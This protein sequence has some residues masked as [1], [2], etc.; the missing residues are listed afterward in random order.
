M[1][2]TERNMNQDDEHLKLL[3][4]FHYVVGGITALFA[5]FPALH[6]IVGLIM[7]F[8][9]F[10][11]EAEGEPPPELFGWFFVVAGAVMVVIGWTIALVI[12]TAGRFLARRKHHLFCLVVAGVE[13]LFFPFGTV[14]GVFTIIVLMRPSVQQAFEANGPWQQ[15]PPGFP[16]A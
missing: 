12:L 16:P 15:P 8:A 13:C 14:L 11:A 6:V 7:V 10:P 1:D 5:S 2:R 4:V 3:S 9:P